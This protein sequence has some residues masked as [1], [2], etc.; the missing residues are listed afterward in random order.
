MSQSYPPHLA[1]PHRGSCHA[2]CG[3]GPVP[4]PTA[5]KPHP[6]PRPAPRPRTSPASSR[7]PRNSSLSCPHVAGWE[8]GSGEEAGGER[9]RRPRAAPFLRPGSPRRLHEEGRGHCTASWGGRCLWVRGPAS[10]WVAMASSLRGRRCSDSGQRPDGKDRTAASTLRCAAG[11]G[12]ALPGC[13]GQWGRRPGGGAQPPRPP[14]PVSGETRSSGRG[15][16]PL[17]P[18][19]AISRLATARQPTLPGAAAARSGL[20]RPLAASRRGT[21]CVRGDL[22]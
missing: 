13:P 4:P 12:G 14:D 20:G 21:A 3:P 8:P 10:G 19:G 17:G 18:R 2:A 6:G 11:R 15:P 7:L 5:S 22:G 1:L 16:G 9:T